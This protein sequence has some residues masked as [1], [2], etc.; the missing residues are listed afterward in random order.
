LSV[1][2][3]WVNEYEVLVQLQERGR[4]LSGGITNLAGKQV[5]CSLLFGF[6]TNKT[7]VPQETGIS[8]LVRWLS[9]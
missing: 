9:G 6:Q 2:L 5:F 1:R 7:M 3:G 4:L 8:E